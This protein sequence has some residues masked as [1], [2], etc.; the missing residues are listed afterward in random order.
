MI[1]NKAFLNDPYFKDAEQENMKENAFIMT[2]AAY[3]H[4]PNILKYSFELCLPSCP[5]HLQIVV[6]FNV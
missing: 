6:P 2:T 3:S 1:L 5:F 4:D